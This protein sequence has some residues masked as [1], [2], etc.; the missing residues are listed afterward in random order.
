MTKGK[1]SRRLR[2][3]GNFEKDLLGKGK[4]QCAGSR[5][6]AKQ[7]VQPIGRREARDSKSKVCK[8]VCI[9]STKLAEQLVRQAF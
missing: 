5:S 9:G 6:L 8:F 3:G 2:F 4:D 1:H 7:I